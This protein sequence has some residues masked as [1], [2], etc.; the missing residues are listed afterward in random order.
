MTVFEEQDLDVAD[1]DPI[2]YIN[3]QFPTE[4]SLEG[5]DA[6]LSKTDQE[7][8]YLNSSIS[9]VGPGG[10]VRAVGCLLPPAMRRRCV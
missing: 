2:E 3:R 10:G 8:K 6:F 7:I 5:L 9:E 1:F 4:A